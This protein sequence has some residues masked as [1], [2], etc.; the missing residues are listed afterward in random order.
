MDDRDPAFSEIPMKA[1]ES[2]DKNVIARR[3][4]VR[5]SGGIL[6]ASLFGMACDGD[7]SGLDRGTVRVLVSGHSTGV[8]NAGEVHLMGNGIDATVPVPATG[9]IE[10][11]L[12]LGSYQLT[13]TPPAGHTLAAG[14]TAQ[15][16]VVVTPGGVVEA[17]FLIVTSTAP[18]GTGRVT[19]TGLAAGAAAGGSAQ[20]VR[21]DITG[22]QPV[23][24]NVPATGSVDVALPVGT[25]QLTYTLPAGYTLAQGQTAQRT[26]TI[27]AGQTSTT[28]FQVAVTGGGGGGTAGA[29][30]FSDFSAALGNSTAA[31]TDGGKWNIVA[32][33]GNSLDVIA[34]ASVGFPSANVLRVIARTSAQGFARLA[35]T[36][37]GIPNV[38]QSFFYRWYYRHE[39]P[40]LNDNSQHPIESGQTGG[41][42]WSFSNETISNTT[43]RPEFRPGGD[44]GN[45]L[46][47]RWTGPVLQR[48]VTY[49]F[50][51]QIHKISN[52]EM[53]MHARVYSAGG[54]LIADDDDFTNDRLGNT[55]ANARS[56]ADNPLLHFQTPGGSQLDEVRAGNNGISVGDWGPDLLY[57]YQGG[58]AIRNDTWCGPFGT[59]AGER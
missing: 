53:R 41:L 29:I 12:P 32:D 30:F 37:L 17:A 14:Q 58:F 59:I 10:Q 45:A 31:K 26:V 36:G 28:T 42:D 16:T 24:A 43:W 35:K 2:L 4:F 8:A 22:Q 55:G 15:R 44:Q 50:E 39:Q 11:V 27:T 21:T 6:A 56:L 51:L 33:P 5:N 38:G 9:S 7:S 48:S 3:A 25:Y 54:A 19:V 57:A 52:T 1:L 20:F 47:A 46:Y 23:T 13:Y 18:T 49:R 34:G 40:S